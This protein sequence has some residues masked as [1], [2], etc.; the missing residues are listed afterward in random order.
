MAQIAGNLRS[1]AAAKGAQFLDL[2]DMLQGREVCSRA[3]SL[4]TSSNPPSPTRSEWARFLVSGIG[5]GDLQE[6]FHPNAYG[7]RALGRCLT[8][9]AA[10]AGAAYTCRNVAGAGPETMTLAPLAAA[11]R[12][13]APAAG[14]VR[15]V[16]RS[17]PPRYPSRK[18]HAGRR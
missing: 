11:A 16:T 18:G 13:T 4:A 15:A 14:R 2:R 7:E 10:Q 8:L 6:S 3:T 1:V 5:Q 9:V 17:W 12:S